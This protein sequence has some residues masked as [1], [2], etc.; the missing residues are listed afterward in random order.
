VTHHTYVGAP[1]VVLGDHVIEADKISADIL[2]WHSEDPNYDKIRRTLGNL[3]GTRRYFQPYEHVVSPARTAAER[4]KTTFDDLLERGEYAARTA[5]E[6][7]GLTPDQIDCIVVSSSTGDGV[8]GLDFHLQNALGLRKN[9]RHRSMTQAAC[10]GGALSL[11]Y[12]HEYLAAHPQDI[13]LWVL[14]ESLSSIYQRTQTEPRDHILKGLWGDCVSAG[15]AARR[16]FGAGLRIEDTLEYT[17]PGTTDRYAKLTDE[18]GDH[19]ISSAASLRSV[20]DAAP[21]LREWLRERGFDRPD[22]GVMHPGGP[23]IIDKLERELDLPEEILRH[24]R[25][26]VWEEGN[27]GGPTLFSALARTHKEPPAHGARF[28]LLGIG[29]GVFLPV[30]IG[31]WFDPDKA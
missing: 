2:E 16:P 6:R 30:V 9:V 15:V 7:A 23:A 26:V 1:V 5:I 24:S 28:V 13:V 11:I 14:G 3:P 31:T 20:T 25:A 12:A 8:P 18:R 4:K 17:I 10:A 29:P 27:L 19:F 21:D 22:F